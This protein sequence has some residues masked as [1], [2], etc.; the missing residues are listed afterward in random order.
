M[1]LAVL[2]VN[3]NI[4]NL[5]EENLIR[6]AVENTARDAERIESLLR[7]FASSQTRSSAHED[8]STDIETSRLLTM[9]WLLSPD[10]LSLHLS[11]VVAGSNIVKLSLFDLNGAIAG[12]TDPHFISQTK[13]ESPLFSRAAAGETSSELVK[14]YD[15]VHLDGVMRRIDAVEVYLPL[16]ETK[17]GKVIGVMEIYRDVVN[18][19]TS[20]IHDTKSTVLRTT[21]SAMGGLFAVLFGFIVAANLSLNRSARREAA[22]GQQQL[23]ER[24]RAQEALERQ[25]AALKQSNAELEQFASVA[26][27]DL[28]EPLRMVTSYAQLLKRRYQGKLDTDAEEIIAYAVDGA[29]RMQRLINDL[30]AYSRVGT[31][32]KALEPIDCEAVFGRALA[33]L[34]MAVE[35][36]GA[37]V[38]H[39]P[40]PRVLGD[41]S[42]LGQLLQNLIGNALKYRGEKP[43]QVHVG[44]ARQDGA[45]LFSVTDNGIGIDP[46]YHDRIFLIFQRLHTREE[47]PG[48]GIGLALCKRI[49]ERHGGRIWVESRPGG[50][51]TFSFTI[52]TVGVDGA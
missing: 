31:Q 52:P 24:Q 11:D 51:A 42:Q 27:H 3:R 22:L 21:L 32:G 38:T 34:R 5:T 17:Q 13:R 40:L 26:S 18:D 45:W 28:Q 7:S 8:T 47:Y 19:V 14:E 30:L 48:T 15:V 37:T 1:G 36:S 49:V 2:L 50:G 33:N 25:A 41:A 6:I 10:G 44:V 35:E 4:G 20:Q 9:E 29:T 39:D 46:K 16:R 43:P 12:S 23:S